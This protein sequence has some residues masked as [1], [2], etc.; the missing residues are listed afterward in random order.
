MKMRRT[1]LKEAR[2][3]LGLSALEL[4]ERAGIR[5]ERVFAVERGRYRPRKG[6][7]TAWANAL[8]LKPECAFPELFARQK[9]A[10]P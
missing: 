7:A 6:E 8:N 10:N 2:L 9:G 3:S 4:G 1:E 5:E